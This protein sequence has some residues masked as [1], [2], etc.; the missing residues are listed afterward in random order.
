MLAKRHSVVPLL[1]LHTASACL[2]STRF[3]I[4][5]FWI[6]FFLL[7]DV[8]IHHLVGL[9]ARFRSESV[10]SDCDNRF[11]WLI[12]LMECLCRRNFTSAVGRCD[13]LDPADLCQRLRLIHHHRFGPF[14]AHGLPQR[15]GSR[16]NGHWP[17]PRGYQ[18]SLYGQVNFNR[19][20]LVFCFKWI[21]SFH[22]DS[23]WV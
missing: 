10:S 14:L 22:S 18:R 17:L 3:P 6:F 21:Y 19:P 2:L 11:G 12:L 8:I 5:I 20:F 1:S 16:Q 15:S 23:G 7:V 4:P 13:R 9:Y